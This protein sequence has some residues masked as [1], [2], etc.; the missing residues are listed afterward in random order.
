M[1]YKAL[2]FLKNDTPNHPMRHAPSFSIFRCFKSEVQK[3]REL[4]KVTSWHMG[5]EIQSS[6][7]PRTPHTGCDAAMNTRV[8]LTMVTAEQVT[9]ASKAQ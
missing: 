7:L 3:L 9:Q 1:L 6:V 5:S 8:Q 2:L 4:S